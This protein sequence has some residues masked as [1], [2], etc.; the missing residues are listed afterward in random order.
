MQR[1]T[2]DPWHA[3]DL[4]HYDYI[5]YFRRI[6]KAMDTNPNKSEQLDRPERTKEL[7]DRIETFG[8][9][10]KSEAVAVLMF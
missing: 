5:L 10:E 4:L 2:P 9:P 7:L 3:H 8:T 6:E 1:T